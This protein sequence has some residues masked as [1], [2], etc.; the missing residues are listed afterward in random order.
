IKQI[1]DIIRFN[2][3][4]IELMPILEKYHIDELTADILMN[5]IESAGVSIPASSAMNE[6]TLNDKAS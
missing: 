5:E 2:E 4:V 1:H 6:D 3:F